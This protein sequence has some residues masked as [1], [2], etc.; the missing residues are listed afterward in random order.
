MA[1]TRRKYTVP[2]AKNV[3]RRAI[4]EILDPSPTDVSEIWDHFQS[5]C[6][7][8]GCRLD[9]LNRGAHID[10]AE[11]DGGNQLG[12]LVLACG[13]CNGDEKR[14]EGW[15]EFT[16]RRTADPALRALREARILE[17]RETHPRHPRPTGG[18]IDGLVSELSELVDAFGTTCAELRVA[19]RGS[20]TKV[21][22]ASEVQGL[23][24]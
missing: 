17:W 16:S 18:A 21:D 6:A 8:Y 20:A 22:T 24:R 11:T 9:R 23:Q 1:R 19:V 14:E 5:E 13:A 12:N 3:M 15:R 2:Q 7:Y 4:A 10:H